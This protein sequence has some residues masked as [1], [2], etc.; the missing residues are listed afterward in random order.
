MASRVIAEFGDQS[1][2][3]LTWNDTTLA[4]QS[5]AI[6]TRTRGVRMSIQR[7][8]EANRI[9]ASAGSHAYSLAG[10]NLAWTQVRGSE[11]PFLAAPVDLLLR[12]AGT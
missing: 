7:G 5:L 11:G 9:F 12:F 3:T 1:T 10:R 8:T 4:W 6:R 2:V